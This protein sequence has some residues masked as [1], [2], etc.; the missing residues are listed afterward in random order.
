[1]A[2]VT[3]CNYFGTQENK[4]CHCFHFSPS[5]CH[6]VMGPD[7]MIVVFEC[8]VLSQFF[9][10][11]LSISSRSSSVPLHF[12]WLEWYH[13]HIWSCYFSQQSWFQFVIHPEGLIHPWIVNHLYHSLSKRSHWRI[14]S[15]HR[16]VL[17]LSYF[18]H[19]DLCSMMLWFIKDS[20]KRIVSLTMKITVF[21]N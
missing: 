10:S 2:A 19:R 9:H 21:E 8:W 16:V 11:S 3:I 14:I 13:V 20:Y 4:I 17:L 7:A 12:L 18:T 6:E 1:M 5:I 15:M